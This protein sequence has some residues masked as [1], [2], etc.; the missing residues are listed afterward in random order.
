MILLI[1]AVDPCIVR[2]YITIIL[3]SPL[4]WKYQYLSKLIYQASAYGTTGFVFFKVSLAAKK[5]NQ[6]DIDSLLTEFFVTILRLKLCPKQG[7]RQS[8]SALG[9]C[10]SAQAVLWELDLGDVC[11]DVWTMVQVGSNPLSSASIGLKL[12]PWTKYLTP[13]EPT[14]IHRNKHRPG[15]CYRLPWWDLIYG[16]SNLK[17]QPT[18]S[19]HCIMVAKAI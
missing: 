8:L 10:R 19:K 15:L 1:S 3:D 2:D 18:T 9:Q 12:S 17:W 5:S 16:R 14:F 6:F 13:F 11:Y 4:S 7:S